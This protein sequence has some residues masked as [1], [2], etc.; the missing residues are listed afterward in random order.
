M[1][2]QSELETRL[3]RAPLTQSFISEGMG[4]EAAKKKA[5][6]LRAAFAEYFAS[7]GVLDQS[8]A[9]LQPIQPDAIPHKIPPGRNTNNQAA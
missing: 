8:K 3:N 5:E 4:E 2:E 7:R 6:E 9:P 1:L